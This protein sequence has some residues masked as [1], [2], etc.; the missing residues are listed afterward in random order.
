MAIFTQFISYGSVQRFYWAKDRDF[1]PFGGYEFN[2]EFI[3]LSLY[4][5]SEHLPA[6]SL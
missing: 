5:V 3:S 4:R 1:A 2:S 6:I